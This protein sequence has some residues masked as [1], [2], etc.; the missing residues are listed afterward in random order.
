MTD[1][2][3][4]LSCNNKMLSDSCLSLFCFS[5]YFPVFLLPA[6]T[7]P[8]CPFPESPVHLP[9]PVCFT[10]SATPLHPPDTCSQVSFYCLNWPVSPSLRSFC[11][12][13]CRHV[14]VICFLV[15]IILAWF[16]SCFWT[17]VFVSV[18]GFSVCLDLDPCSESDLCFWFF[19]ACCLLK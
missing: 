14:P 9:V 2:K 11:V 3:V 12:F 13:S 18:P 10:S 6:T 7:L 19:P 15:C 5:F 4:K 8:S 17:L 16:L 1:N